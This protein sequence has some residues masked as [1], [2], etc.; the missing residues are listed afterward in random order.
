MTEFSWF[1]DIQMNALIC[2]TNFKES[3]GSVE[4]Y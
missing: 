2:V 4:K 1:P 3:A